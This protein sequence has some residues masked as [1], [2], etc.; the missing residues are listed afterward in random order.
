[1]PDSVVIFAEV[2][3]SVV[4]VPL[5]IVGP[6]AK[7]T[8]PVPVLDAI[9]MF[10]EV[11]PDDA[12]GDDAVTARTPVAPP[13][14]AMVIDPVALVI[15]MLVPAVSSVRLYPVPLPISN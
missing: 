11:P 10:G 13:L 8:A 1:M 15:V 3:A 12:S 2:D 4:T 9:L 7:T 5:E 6:S 14:A